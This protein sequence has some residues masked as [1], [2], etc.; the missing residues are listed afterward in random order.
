MTTLEVHF[1]RLAE[2]LVSKG[3]RL[4]IAGTDAPGLHYNV[5][6][7]G[8]L[9]VAQVIAESSN[10]GAIK[11][12]MRLGEDR[13]YK[14]IRSYGFGQQTGIELPGEARG[15]V[16]PVKRWSKTSI[17]AMSMGQEVGVTAIQAVSAVS[18]IANDGVYNAPRIVAGIT[19]PNAGPQTITFHPAEQRRIVSTLTAAQMRTCP[20]ECSARFAITE[21]KRAITSVLFIPI[22]PA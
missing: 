16:K 7:M 21:V 19:P 11:I 20:L 10:V 8:V 18:S 2:C 13:L 12:G 3:W 1:L 5:S 9:T 6:G 14:Y 22:T 4:D 17:G 15:L